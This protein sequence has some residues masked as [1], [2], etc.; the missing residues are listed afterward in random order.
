MFFFLSTPIT[1]SNY[2]LILSAILP[3]ALLLI[4][5]YRSDRVERE[6]SRILTSLIVAGI[7]STMLAQIEERVGV[8]LLDLFLLPTPDCIT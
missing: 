2:L 3:A 5:V 6:S 4:Q 1:M 7:L 8:T